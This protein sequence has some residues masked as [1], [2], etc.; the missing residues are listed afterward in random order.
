MHLLTYVLQEDTRAL[1][2]TFKTQYGHT[3]AARM[4]ELRDLPPTSARIIWYRQ[5][6]HQLDTYMKRVEAVLGKGARSNVCGR[7]MVPALAQ[8]KASL[9]SL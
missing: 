1:Q 2:D 4:A 3:Q 5:L 8:S 6:E 9:G 7:A